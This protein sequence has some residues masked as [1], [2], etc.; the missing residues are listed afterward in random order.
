MKPMTINNRGIEE[1]CVLYWYSCILN[2]IC[3][4]YLG[5]QY[6]VFFEKMMPYLLSDKN[7]IAPFFPTD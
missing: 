3:E 2:L 5:I 7:Y 6:L 4:I 1:H